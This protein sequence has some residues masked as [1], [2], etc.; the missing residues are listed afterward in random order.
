MELTTSYYR[1]SG[2]SSD[3]VSFLVQRFDVDVGFVAG[4]SESHAV[5]LVRDDSGTLRFWRNLSTTGW[6]TGLWRSLQGDLVVCSAE[7]AL[8]VAPAAQLRME[9]DPWRVQ[10]TTATL[11]GVWGLSNKNAF[12]WGFEGGRPRNFS[13]DGS[14]WAP[15]PSPD[16][17]VE[18]M[19]G[20]DGQARWVSGRGGM[21]ARFDAGRWHEFQTPV[22]EILVSIF[23]AKPGECYAVGNMGT[24]LEGSDA[25]WGVI[26]RIPG[27]VEG[28]LQGVAKWGDQL[29]IAASRLGLWRR[30]GVSAQ[31][32]CVDPKLTAVALDVRGDL[33]VGCDDSIGSSTDGISFKVRGVGTVERNIGS[34]PL[35]WFAP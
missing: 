15:E 34:Q 9:G 11:M 32:E 22:P 28:D 18:S 19:H 20:I 29:W 6:L 12:A 33:V 1:H 25:G 24:V 30:T 17:I 21:V 23:V 5:S 31:F 26:G 10:E 27:A 4:E 16:F 14:R 2:T 8:Y 35:G 13:W 3:A 7:G